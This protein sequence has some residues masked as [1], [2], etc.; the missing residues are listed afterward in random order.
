ME[1]KRIEND[2]ESALY[3]ARLG[4]AYK[5]YLV[6]RV[7]LNNVIIDVIIVTGYY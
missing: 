4:T 5:D 6:Q 1:L 3:Y 2:V 7:K